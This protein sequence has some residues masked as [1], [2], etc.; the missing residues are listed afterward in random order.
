MGKNSKDNYSHVL[1]Y[2]G[3]FGGVQGLNILI[4]LVR[5]K[6]AAVLLGPSGMG[7]V[8]LF[9]TTVNF[10]SQA[11]NL[12]I[13][14]G[15]VRQ[16]SELYDKGDE[17]Q[18]N[19]FVKVVR[20]WSLLTALL[21]MLVCVVV[22][23]LLSS[24][25]FS[26]GDHT[27]HF[28]LLAPA[29]G[30]LAI[31]GGE[32]AIMKGTRRLKPLAMVQLISVFA[33][34]IISI[35]IY[36]FFGQAGI[37]PVIVLV[38]FATAVAT[39][40]Y[41]YAIYPLRLRGAK[42]ILGEGMEMVRLG[43]AFILA[44]ILNSGAEMFIRSYLNIAGDLQMVGYYNASYVLVIVY[45]GM[46]FSAMETDYYPRLSGVNSY[47]TS[48]NEVV[49]RQIEVSLLL[50]SP[51]LA[52]LVMLLPVVIPVL[53]STDFL[54]VVGMAQVAALA[55]YA[56]AITLPISFLTLAKSDPVGYVLL[57]VLYDVV[58]VVLII[59]GFSH[60]GLWGTGL[61]ITVTHVIELAMVFV[62][63]HLRFGYRM[64]VSVMQFAALQLPLGVAV[65]LVTL[66]QSGFFY[67]LLCGILCFVSIAISFTVLRQKTSLWDALVR[68]LKNRLGQQDEE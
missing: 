10:V 44:G 4:S 65:Y 53:Y 46:V 1:K 29:V 6:I 60:W 68:K 5:N 23:P 45:A 37:V 26:W 2:T 55:M 12:G 58:L 54:P 27:L 33:A 39:M 8:S 61:A 50:I 25:T 59:L 28:V 9:N 24:H 21:G 52:M 18:V 3:V 35:S 14:F 16:L 34:L 64:S 49:N 36:Y 66:T 30:F 7:L 17:T 51:L 40:R 56:K 43:V 63:A 67:W 15:A 62:Y 47:H 22:G 48:A 38:A 32:T 31:T 57:D 11:T 13:S 20:A 42:G 19:R 41:S